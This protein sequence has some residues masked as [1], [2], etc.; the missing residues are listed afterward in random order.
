MVHTHNQ[1]RD[2]GMA[3]MLGSESPAPVQYVSIGTYVL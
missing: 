3:G 2:R 1:K